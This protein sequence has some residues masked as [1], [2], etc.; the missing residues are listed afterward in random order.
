MKEQQAKQNNVP[1][2]GIGS[3]AYRYAI[4]FKNFTPPNPMNI[5]DF[6]SEAHRLGLDRVQL[7]ENLSYSHFTAKEL[8]EIKT[9]AK[10]LGLFIELGM[11]DITKENLYKHLEIADELSA[12]FLR[13]VLGE[14][15][16]YRKE[17]PDK[18][19]Q[20]A[21][22]V[23][24]D[25]MPD[26]K[27]LDMTVGIENHFDVATEYL[28]RI[29]EEIDDK[30]LGLIFDTTNCLGFITTPEETLKMI[31]PHLVS[32]HLKD[33][34]VHKVEA[35]YLIRGTILGDGWLNLDEI[36]RSVLFYNPN[37]S[38]IIE[39]T[40][41][42]NPDQSVEETI[43]W[44]KQAIE[45]SVNNLHDALHRTEIGKGDILVGG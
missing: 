1:P 16:L 21:I 29:V 27:K 26:I 7:C 6:L 31:G 23:F 2:V 18:L 34:F 30:H 10:E 5:F 40:I 28:V 38:I 22:E 44:E 11:R 24:K 42:R 14:N 17:N 35:G 45:Q 43:I 41:R 20:Q 32:V 19:T 39:M 3:Y 9:L 13:I 36:L 4:G 15:S 25:T 37:V 33:Y 12:L 8:R